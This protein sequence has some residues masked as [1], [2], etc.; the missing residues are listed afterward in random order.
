[1]VKIFFII[2]TIQI[3]LFGS[4]NLNSIAGKFKTVETNDFTSSIE[5]NGKSIYKFE[6]NINFIKKY[7][8]KNSEIY[9]VTTNLGGNGTLDYYTII[10]IFKDGLYKISQEFTNLSGEAKFNFRNNVLYI[11]LGYE[12]K[13]KKDAVYKNHKLT[14]TKKKEINGY[15][16]DKDC[17]YL[18]ENIYLYYSK[19]KKCNKS[20]DDDMPMALV[21]SINSLRHNPNIDIDMMYKIIQ[22]DCHTKTVKKYNEFK[23]IFVQIK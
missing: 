13:L 18:Y 21:S 1:M 9:I 7:N 8:I 20:L 12:N 2:F 23:K 3:F 11:D 19:V 4:F 15:A 16:K 22:N 14:I 10:E 6:G 17:K 5:L